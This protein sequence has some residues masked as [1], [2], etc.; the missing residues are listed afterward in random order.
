MDKHYLPEALVEASLPPV[1]DGRDVIYVKYVQNGKA[2]RVM[3]LD[4]I[5]GVAS[6]LS[7]GATV[8]YFYGETAWSVER[9]TQNTC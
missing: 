9:N 6:Q 1:F 8:D 7:P 2:V 4:P 3:R 5:R